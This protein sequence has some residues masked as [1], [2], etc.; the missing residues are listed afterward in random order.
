MDK[1]RELS[2]E[3]AQ[4]A[5]DIENEAKRITWPSRQEAVKSTVAVIL[6]SGLF[7]AFLAG[8]DFIFSMAIRYVLS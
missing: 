5:K 3:T 2:L 8:V 1:I 6:I 7:A 4:F